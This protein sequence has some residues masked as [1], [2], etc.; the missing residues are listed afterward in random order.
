MSNVLYV[1]YMREAKILV[2]VFELVPIYFFKVQHDMY[3]AL[4]VFS[5][6]D[7]FDVCIINM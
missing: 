3:S 6:K 7:W 2:R 1:Q 5:F 4:Q